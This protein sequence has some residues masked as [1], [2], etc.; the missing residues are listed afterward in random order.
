MNLVVLSGRLGQDSELSYTKNTTPVLN[1]S[2]A[3][4]KFWYS[5]EGERKSKT[6]WHTIQHWGKSAEKLKTYLTKGTSVTIQGEL[7]IDTW[8]DK[9]G[10]SRSKSYIIANEIK[11]HFEGKK[12]SPPENNKYK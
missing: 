5:K 4:E 8:E 6:T 1:F 11:I 9:Q 10:N 7:N 3:T 2:M 12:L